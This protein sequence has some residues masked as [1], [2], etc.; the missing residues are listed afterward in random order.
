VCFLC[1]RDSN[2]RI[3]DIL[4]K[5]APFMKMYGEYVKNFDRAMDLV[6]TWSQRSSHFKSVVQNI[7]VSVCVC[8][9]VCVHVFVRDSVEAAEGRTAH[10]NDWNGA[11]WNGIRHM[12]TMFDVFDT[13]PLIPL[14]PS[15]PAHPPVLCMYGKVCLC[16]RCTV[17][18]V[19]TVQ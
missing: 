18:C 3:G 8:A 2:P 9:R 12:E 4:Q 16:Y 17:C 1:V 15:P 6:S 11:E 14:Q 13:I 5:L 10:N 7:Q 19:P